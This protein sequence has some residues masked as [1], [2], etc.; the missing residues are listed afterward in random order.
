[1]K[2][3]I[4]FFILIF[5]FIF[6][7]DYSIKGRIAE[8][9]YSLGIGKNLVL[10][11]IDSLL[12]DVSVGG[13][14]TS[15]GIGA[16]Y[17]RDFSSF[18]VK[19]GIE[20]IL[21]KYTNTS[22]LTGIIYPWGLSDISVGAL[23]KQEK[24][25]PYFVF[26][27]HLGAFVPYIR[28]SD[29][30]MLGLNYGFDFEK[31]IAK[32]EY[33]RMVYPIGNIETTKK[34]VT[35]K[36]FFLDKGKVY[37]DGEELPLSADGMFIKT[38]EIKDYGRNY[39][40]II[41]DGQY[42]RRAKHDFYVYR[43]YPFN[44][45]EEELQKKWDKI[46][47][48]SGYPKEDNFLPDNPVNR[49]DFYLV[50]GRLMGFGKMGYSFKDYFADV[51]D[52]EL[53]EYLYSFYGKGYI[54]TAQ[55]Q[56]M[57]DE[58]ILRQDALTVLSRILPEE[59]DMIDFDFEDISSKDWVYLAVNKLANAKVLNDLS[60]FPRQVLTRKDF[61]HYLY[62]MKD[63]FSSLQ[64]TKQVK[65]DEFNQVVVET[66]KEVV[67]YSKYRFTDIEVLSPAK[68]ERTES[69]PFYVK[70]FAPPGLKVKINNQEAEA[71]HLGRFAGE[72]SIVPGLNKLT[73]AVN[74]DVRERYVLFLKKFLD[75]SESD[76]DAMSIEKVSTITGYR[77]DEE[78]FYPEEFVSKEELILVLFNLGY[79]TEDRV[80]KLLNQTKKDQA[81]NSFNKY[82]TAEE[83]VKL[84]NLVTGSNYN[85]Y[86]GEE[87]L[88]RRSLAVL[89][90]EIPN[91]KHQIINYF[92]VKDTKK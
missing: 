83:A 78:S 91:V 65:E 39:F 80:N 77:I 50:L 87:I 1:M 71:N 92:E 52:Q 5:G 74:D 46:F 85:P 26:S 48:V 45:L 62:I 31:K 23:L 12:F 4:C 43:K 37:F 82:S 27:H 8:D 18:S 84:F 56:F 67:D 16:E 15:F 73:I 6:S 53:K 42:T 20:D 33:F 60:V 54:R 79:F 21:S 7:F 75:L 49:G 69:A 41:M 66:K 25:I 89:L 44:D 3:N 72:V 13:T 35:I 58:P 11:D 40:S 86:W 17:R 34:I 24:I 9:F 28:L 68:E 90:S 19:V 55:E 70:G 88:T 59:G 14:N 22:Y 63:N 81:D 57:P 51:S 32:D 61:Y 2:K 29:R 76:I 30:V 38:V 64:D 36:G 10:S 47:D